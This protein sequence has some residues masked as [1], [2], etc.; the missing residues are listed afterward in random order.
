LRGAAGLSEVLVPTAG[1]GGEFCESDRKVRS[2]RLAVT[3]TSNDYLPTAGRCGA[4][5]LPG[6]GGGLE[7]RHERVRSK[8]N[9]V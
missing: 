9:M 3:F 5:L 8:A 1:R 7:S 4:S 6:W 2:K